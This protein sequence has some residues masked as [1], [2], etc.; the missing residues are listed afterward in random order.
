MIEFRENKKERTMAYK[1]GSRE[2]ITLFPQ[3]IDEYIGEEHPVRAYDTFIEVLNP[4]EINL[5][6]DPHKVGNSAYDPK[7]MLKLVVYGYSYGIKG[8]RKL[9]RAV[10]ENLAF[11]WLMGGLKPDHKTISEFRKN[12]KK[13]LKSVLRQCARMCMKLGLIEGNILF[14][15]GTKI[16][17]NASRGKTYSQGQYQS[18]LRGIDNRIEKLLEECD[19]IDEEEKEDGSLVKMKEGVTDQKKLRERIKGI[20][21]EFETK[22]EK[23]KDKVERTINQTDP[24]SALMRSIHGSHAS[25]NAQTVVDDKNGLI[26]H[27]DAVSETKDI[28]QLSEQVQQAKEV[29]GK[30]CAVA[31]ADA[32]YSNTKE[33]EKLDG[34]NIKVVV[35][36]QRQ[37]LHKPEKPFSKSHFTYNAQEDCYYCP[38]GH[39]LVYSTQKTSEEQLVYRIRDANLCRQCKNFGICTNA[40]QGRK[41]ARLYREELKEKIEKQFNEPESQEIYSRRKTRAEHPFGHIKHN[42]GIRNFLL[43]GREG[44][45]AEI[46]IGAT[47]FNIARMITLLGGVLEFCFKVQSHA[48]L[49]AI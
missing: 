8:S 2:Q 43:R 20:L 13:V 25:Y 26:I 22:G 23:N 48:G 41:I 3:S 28:N 1:C 14:V 17:A 45:K 18:K 49:I 31:C 34:K 29:M 21:A 9:E 44:A 38:E 42:L 35:P 10:H 32:G 12:N 39:P 46:S 24:E 5:E 6:I 47:C 37:A 11:I 33:L 40:R 27:A 16:R 7:A 19:R 36:S 30:N 15:D 4:H